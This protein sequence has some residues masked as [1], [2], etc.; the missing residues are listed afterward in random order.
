MENMSTNDLE[1][2]IK[3]VNNTIITLKLALFEVKCDKAKKIIQVQIENYNSSLRQMLGQLSA[4]R[5][6]GSQ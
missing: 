4:R 6:P 3:N 1:T 2:K 5:E